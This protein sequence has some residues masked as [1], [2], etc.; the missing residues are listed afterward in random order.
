[1]KR[2][3]VLGSTGS[4]GQN[5][6]KVIA[7]LGEKFRVVGLS[8]YSNVPT[9][10]RQVKQFKPKWI[11]LVDE[12][13][14]KRAKARLPSSCKL[15]SGRGGLQD[16]I[17]ESNADSVVL[18]VSGA[19][20]LMPLFK[21]VAMKKTVI[22]ANKEALVIAG[23]IIMPLAARYGVRIL[24]VD[25]EQ[26]AIWQCLEGR[27]KKQLRRVYLTASGGPFK[28]YNSEQ[29]KG[30]SISDV[31]RHPRWNM[32]KRITVDSATL[33]NKGL[34]II[35]AMWLFDLDLSQIKVVIHPEAVIH[36]MVEFIDGVILAQLSITDMRIPIQY[37]LTY[38]QRLANTLKPVNFFKL[39][40]LNFQK[41]DLR[42]F[43]CLRLAIEAAGEGGSLPCVLNAA[44]EMAVNAFLNK[45]IKFTDIPTIIAK[46]LNR[47]RKIADPCLQ[48]ILA[49][50][51]W[52]RAEARKIIGN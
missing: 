19:E 21:A 33:M 20:A 10:L 51:D 50:D 45:R 37:A 26:S 31:L 12:L 52:A 42:R 44:D 6:L 13:C 15:L 16:L 46:V 2:I 38:P 29:L 9:L 4:V 28:N 41:P 14:A 25:S 17:Q 48:E 34:E 43:P 11:C 22:L 35:E 27:E 40:K 1:M 30:I 7:S 49:V 24:P 36:S 3:V 18:A 39:R 32:G 23:S 8:A 47:H 5:T